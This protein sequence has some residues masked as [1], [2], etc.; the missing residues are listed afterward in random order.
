[1]KRDQ[2]PVKRLLALALAVGILFTGCQ[3]IGDREESS[4]PAS[5]GNQAS[6]PATS[7]EPNDLSPD[8]SE[9]AVSLPESDP[10]SAVVEPVAA[11]PIDPESLAL[12]DFS[13]FSNE[14][15]TWG[16]GHQMNEQNQPTACVQLQ[17]TYGDNGG[18][19][20]FPTDEKKMYLTFDQGYENGYTTKI[21]DVLKEKD[22]PA[23]F[24]LTY[25]YA[26]RNP[27]LIQ[28]MIDEGHVLAHHSAA[29]PANGM[30]SLTTE[31]IVADV[32]KL[33][34]YIVENYDY[35]MTYFRPPAGIFSERSLEVLKSLG[36]T[37]VQWSFAYL[38]YDVNNQPDPATALEKLT[39]MAHPGGIPLL[40]SVSSTNA[41][42]L[43]DAIDAWRA[44][45]YEL[46]EFSLE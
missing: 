34:N 1:M 44:A 36:Y 9:P 35:Q 14:P 15:V 46:C 21:L 31:E 45:G 4:E 30:P 6:E 33:H 3:R 11:T 12:P 10:S 7:S 23:M 16:P 20:L 19:F 41:E 18:V 22:C 43:G 26:E 2:F 8:S 27:E 25:S 5:S 24:F 29:H 42:V 28:R 13:A 32:A 39:N 38:D 40:H 17:E 37:S